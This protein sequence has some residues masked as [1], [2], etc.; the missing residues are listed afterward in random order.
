MRGPIRSILIAALAVCAFAA[1]TVGSAS[2]ALLGQAANTSFLAIYGN[3]GSNGLTVV[4]VGGGL[5]RNF[6]F[7][8]NM[9]FKSNK[10]KFE[11]GTAKAKAESK[12]AFIGGTLMS[13]KTGV[14]NPLSFTVQFADFQFSEVAGVGLFPTYSD[15]SDR[16]WIT[17]ICSA[18]TGTLC[19]V[20]PARAPN[21]LGEVKVEDVS[22]N[23]GPGFVVQGTVWG[24]WG[25][26]AAGKCPTITLNLPPKEIVEK[27]PDE[28][29]YVTQTK[30]GFPAVGEKLEGIEG[31]FCLTSANNDW[32]EG[33]E[34]AITLNNTA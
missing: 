18:E 11:I 22:L 8:E 30:A 2:A 29:L 3:P 9:L 14:N 12:E 4:P 26:G 1:L 33:K 24:V 16:P 32:Y 19:R 13:N 28:T 31:V 15:T 10:A 23:L 25:N 20:D 7:G 34:P 27:S 5:G 6:G 21:A 17:E